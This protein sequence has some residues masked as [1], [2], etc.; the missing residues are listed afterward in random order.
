LLLFASPKDGKP[1]D[2]CYVEFL[3]QE[4]TPLLEQFQQAKEKGKDSLGPETNFPVEILDK[5]IKEKEQVDLVVVLS[6]MVIAKTK[7]HPAGSIVAD[8]ISEYRDKVNPDLR[9]VCVDLCGVCGVDTADNPQDS[10][11]DILLTGYSDSILKFLSQRRKLGSQVEYVENVWANLN[12]D[13]KGNRKRPDRKSPSNS[14]NANANA[15]DN[16]NDNDDD[17]MEVDK[18]KDGGGEGNEAK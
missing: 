3:A 5:A 8:K 15:N 6:D 1:D 13:E 12:L 7:H 2:P 11:K 18:D 14:N 4:E 9:F 10:P 16:D 17:E